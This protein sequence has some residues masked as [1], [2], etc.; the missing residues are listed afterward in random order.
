[1]RTITPTLYLYLMPNSLIK[2]LLLI[3]YYYKSRLR[4]ISSCSRPLKNTRTDEGNKGVDI[5][6]LFDTTFSRR[7]H[8]ASSCSYCLVRLVFVELRL[9]NYLVPV[10]S[11]V[12][13]IHFFRFFSFTL[14][15][16]TPYRTIH[17][18]LGRLQVISPV[19]CLCRKPSRAYDTLTK[20]FFI[21]S[22]HVVL[23]WTR[24]Q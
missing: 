21:L 12:C 9:Y 15:S 13:K 18:W 2:L 23:F 11:C 10:K 3:F 14:T 19:G 20:A 1:M 17:A 5:N 7:Q 24:S 8:R 6:R 16:C 22:M 4:K